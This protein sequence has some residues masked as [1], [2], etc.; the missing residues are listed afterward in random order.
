[1]AKNKNKYYVVWRGRETG[2]FDSWEACRA[3]IDGFQ[4]AQYKGYPTWEEA[5]EGHINGYWNET[6][7]RK[8]D[9]ADTEVIKRSFITDVQCDAEGTMTYS[10]LDNETLTYIY[11]S[12]KYLDANNNVGQF[13]AIVHALAHLARTS[14]TRPIYTTSDTA[15][16]WTKKRECNTRLC[17]TLNNTNLFDLLIRANSWIAN[18]SFA[19]QILKW[20]TASWGNPPKP[21]PAE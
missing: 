3:S 7:I 1:M 11:Q 9:A 15:I 14:D 5:H 18:N 16:A 8:I 19:N 6:I 12:P 2:I 20:N 4:G 13:I 10:I 21:T 17:R